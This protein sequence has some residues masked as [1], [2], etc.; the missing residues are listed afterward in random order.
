MNLRHRRLVL[1]LPAL[2]LGVILGSPRLAAQASGATEPPIPQIPGGRIEQVTVDVVV[3]DR[4]GN[5]VTGLLQEDFTVLEERRPQT[6]VSFD[7]I[8]RSAPSGAPPAS[9]ATPAAPRIATNVGVL[10][11]GAGARTFVV[12]FDDLNLTLTGAASAKRAITAFLDRGAVEGDRITL[13]TTSGTA[14]WSTRMRGGRDDLVAILK[15]LEGRRILETA[16][17]RITDFEAV[18]I[19]HYRDVLVAARV[20]DRMERYGSKLMQAPDKANYQNA[21]ELFQRGVVDPFV[22]NMA[23]QTYLKAKLRMEQSQQTID[24]AMRSLGDDRSRKAILLV[25]EGFIEDPSRDGPRRVVESARRAN[26]ALY[27]IDP[28][29]LR[30]LDPMYSAEFGTALDSRDTMSAIADLSREGEGAVIL[31]ER[32]GGFSIRDTNAFD[33]GTVRIGRESQSYYLLGYNPGDIPRDGRFRRIEV[34]VRGGYTVRARQGY[35]APLPDGTAVDAPVPGRD[36]V[37]QHALDAPRPLAEIPLRLSTY[38]MEEAGFNRTRVILAADVDVSRVEFPEVEGHPQASLDTLAVVAHR[39]T[40][41]ALRSD[42]RAV[43]QRRP[44]IG[45]GAGPLW[46]SF[47]REFTVAPGE[48][49]AKVVVRDPVTNRVGTVIHQ[50][51]VPAHDQF[52]LSTPILTDTLND[53]GTGPAPVIMTRRSFPQSAHLF[54]R[55]DVFGAAKG[56]D[57]FPRVRAGHELRRDGLVVGRATPSLIDPTSL[58]NLARMVQIPLQGFAPGDYELVV[59]VTD[60]VTGTTRESVE[61]FTIVPSPPATASR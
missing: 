14:W 19:V 46:Y 40:A 22:E 21:R 25:S 17:E 4:K 5:P 6:I 59:R 8:D 48:H 41:E 26:A 27:Y 20:Q 57:A 13:F 12:I 18:Q 37:L 31:A 9:A 45:S 42:Q 61:S 32:T 35:F 55:F 47:L 29:G 16:N 10:E 15:R 11:K 60:E 1:V 28:S 58:G 33:E 44:G 52:R 39:D 43:I 56:P 50:F 23:L 53:P 30:A 36:P 7:V 3:L 38:V 54:C 51:T 2:G 49:Q 34:K 24:R